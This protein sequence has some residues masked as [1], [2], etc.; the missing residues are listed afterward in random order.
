[1]GQK[2]VEQLERV[3]HAEHVEHLEHME[4]WPVRTCRD[5]EMRNLVLA[6]AYANLS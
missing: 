4:Q 2:S 1:M 5:V 3:E 6:E